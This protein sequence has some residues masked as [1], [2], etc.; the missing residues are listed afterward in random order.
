MDVA[1]GDDGLEVV[2]AVAAASGEDTPHL[3]GVGL[4]DGGDIEAA[5]FEA[6]VGEQ[7]PAQVAQAEQRHGL[8]DVGADDAPMVRS[9]SRTL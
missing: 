6:A 3:L 9:R 8:R 5:L 1:E 2:K 7:G 4:E